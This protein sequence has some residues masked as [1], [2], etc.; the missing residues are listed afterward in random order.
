[1][2]AFVHI[3]KT[4]GSTLLSILRRS[5]GARHC[6]VRLPLA[7]RRREERDLRACVEATD[8]RKVTKL[9]RRLRG[10]SGHHVKPYSD[11]E[12]ACPAIRYITYLR[13]PVAR[14]RS[15]FL[16]RATG[17]TALDFDRWISGEWTHNWQTKMIAGAP[18]ADA[19]IELLATRFGFVGFTERFDEGLVLLRHWL[20]E[21][22]FYPAYR[23][24][25]RLSDKRRPR[26][27]AREMSDMSYLDSSETR[28]RILDANAQDQKVYDF[29]L[30]HLYPRQLAN[31]DGELS[32]DVRELKLHNA[33]ADRLSEPRWGAFMRNY[34][35]KPLLHCRAM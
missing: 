9:Y 24:A 17:H 4:G 11:L 1:M 33:R 12:S 31:Y 35:Y 30:A 5:F 14:F 23:P 3:E 22:G 16:N 25:N 21:P 13:D 7:K 6:D 15:H 28:A 2:Y 10:I 18:N 19:A 8:L 34:V 27:L 20:S 32:A 29:A 26:D